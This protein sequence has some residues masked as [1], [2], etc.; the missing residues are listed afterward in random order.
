MVVVVGRVGFRRG[1][2]L[3]ARYRAADDQVLR[4]LPRGAE[5]EKGLLLDSFAGVLKGSK[6]GAMI[7][8]GKPDQSKLLLVLDGRAKPAM[9]PKDNVGP[10]AAE[11]ALIKA[12]IAAGAKGPTSPQPDRPELKVPQIKPTKPVT[13]AITA[14]AMTHDGQTLI[15]GG[16]G[17][18]RLLDA[19]TRAEQRKL[20]V[21]GNVAALQVSAD[22][23]LLAVAAGEPGLFGEATLFDLV[24]GKPLRQFTGHRDSLYAV[25]LSPDGNKLATGSYDSR[26][27]SGTSPMA[28][29]YTPSSDTTARS[30][31]SRFIRRAAC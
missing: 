10:S 26:S 21:R 31:I 29:S 16:Y 5:A 19:A 24:T 12:W 22:G 27:R 8:P 25:A 20:V 7:V 15:L 14:A 4:R 30:T 11:I 3:C 1:A 13:P 28:A 17:E 6:S 18:V 23:K 9:P 2:G